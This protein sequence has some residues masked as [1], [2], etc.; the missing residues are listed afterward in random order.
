MWAKKEY[1]WLKSFLRKIIKKKK[2]WQIFQIIWDIYPDYPLVQF[3][4]LFI[5]LFAAMD[6]LSALVTTSLY[7][8]FTVCI[9]IGINVWNDKSD[10]VA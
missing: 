6:F 8:I 4:V 9:T 7:L 10:D 5:L 1:W 2:K 3:G